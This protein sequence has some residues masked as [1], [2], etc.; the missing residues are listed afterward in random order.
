MAEVQEQTFDER[1]IQ[2]LEAEM[3]DSSEEPVEQEAP[4]DGIP[5]DAMESEDEAD[6]ALSASETDE[7]SEDTEEGTPEEETEEVTE[8]EKRYKD[9]QSELTKYQQAKEQDAL[10]HSNALAEVMQARY[11]LD[12]RI[13][14]QEQQGQFLVQMMS[15]NAEQY[16][17]IN[18]SQVPPDQLPQLQQAAQNAFMQEQSV[19]NAFAQQQEQAKQVQE[20]ALRREATIARQRLTRT[21]PD[22]DNTY[23]E[24]AKYA[25]S[26][27]V[28]INRF[29]EIVDPALMEMIYDSMQ[30]RTSSQTVEVE[31]PKQARPPKSRL[32]PS[33]PRGLDGKYKKA[34]EAYRKTTDPRQRA[35]SWEDKTKLRLAQEKKGR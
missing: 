20:E 4:I 30:M 15:G 9:A 12:D 29:N 21:I 19:K 6:G 32:A 18:W 14:Q 35:V 7:E 33:Q 25:K 22:F 13:K 17:N 23:P 34:E 31:K 26:R 28:D 2:R 1:M 27:G 24:M 10:E 3:Q 16:R 8:W 5:P 11:A